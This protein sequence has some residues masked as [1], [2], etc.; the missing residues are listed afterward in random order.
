MEELCC[1]AKLT[2]CMNAK[3]LMCAL[4]GKGSL[5]PSLIKAIFQSAKPIGLD[6]LRK[7]SLALEKE[8]ER[9]LSMHFQ[10]FSIQ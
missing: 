5:D 8:E 9:L 4:S 7:Q 1:D 2:V 10:P 3:G 6:N